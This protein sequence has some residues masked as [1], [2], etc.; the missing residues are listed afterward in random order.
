MPPTMT[1][2]QRGQEKM[3]I[4]A[5]RDR[6]ERP[7]DDAGHPGEPGAE[8]EH[9]HKHQ[10]NPVAKHRQHVAIIDPRTDQHAD[11]GAV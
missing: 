1:T 2:T 9:Q 5:E 4:L 3:R 10:L 8:G 7:A 11:P 6:L